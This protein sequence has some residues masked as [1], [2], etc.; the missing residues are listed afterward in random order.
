MSEANNLTAQLTP[1]QIDFY[2]ANGYLCVEDVLSQDEIAELRRVTDEFVEQSR[3]VD[4]NTPIYDLEPGHSREQPRVRRIKNPAAHHAA[5]DS[6]LRHPRILDIVSQLIGPTL[7]SNG[8]KLNMKSAAFGSPIEWHQDWAFYPQTN[9]DLLAVGV[10]IDDM[11]LENGCMLMIP[12]SQAG[13]LY[14]HHQDGIFVGAVTDPEF[15][16]QREEIAPVEVK[17]GGI[18]I[19]HARTL[20]AS[21][22]NR[23]SKPRRLLLLQYCAGDA[24]P[25]SGAPS[26]DAHAAAFV[27]GEPTYA[28]RMTDAPVRIPLPNVKPGGTI[29]EL[30]TQLTKSAFAKPA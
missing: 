11:T 2:R 7:W 30:Q 16:P 1:S 6:V 15:D 8:N 19:H 24:W 21:A 5:Y 27:R 20:H 22:P 25:L 13:P 12:G 9:D 14:D 28:P 10:P 17:A 4:A 18:S 23:S 26:W 3:E 29:Y